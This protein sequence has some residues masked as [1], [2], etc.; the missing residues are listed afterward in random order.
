VDN[1]IPSQIAEIIK[2]DSSEGR[3][4]VAKDIA[5]FNRIEKQ[6]PGKEMFAAIDYESGELI[7][8]PKPVLTSSERPIT[9]PTGGAEAEQKVLLTIV[10][11]SSK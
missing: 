5:A 9:K 10:V 6:L 8:I 3:I 1:V 7:T 4:R 11:V 2:Q